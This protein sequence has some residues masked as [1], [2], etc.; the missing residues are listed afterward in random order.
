MQRCTV[1]SETSATTHFDVADGK[2]LLPEMLLRG[3]RCIPVGCRGGGCGVCKIQILEGSY[4]TGRMS[5]KHICPDDLAAGVVLACQTV[6]L[7]DIVVRPSP[8]APRTQ[9]PASDRTN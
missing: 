5:A 6:P 4:S 2:A 7:T 8:V 3:I 9:S 1:I